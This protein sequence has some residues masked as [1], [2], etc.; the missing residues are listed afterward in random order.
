[1][2]NDTILSKMLEYLERAKKV[3]E[4]DGYLQPTVFAYTN[5]ASENSILVLPVLQEDE[6]PPDLALNVISKVLNAYNVS[7]YFVV[8]E[9]YIIAD[10]TPQ[11]CINIVYVGTYTRRL[12]SLPFKHV[13]T[14][15][16]VF[17]GE[18][19]EI[20]PDNIEGSVLELFQLKSRTIKLTE[21]DKSQ[22]RLMFP[23]HGSDDSHENTL[24]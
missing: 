12:L 20:D 1:L 16:E 3:L 9:S 4:E 2:S 21:K 11:D 5:L 14:S 15:K 7:D 17:F 18:S 23:A 8:S 24:H 6:T 22:I 13:T 10:D 19:V